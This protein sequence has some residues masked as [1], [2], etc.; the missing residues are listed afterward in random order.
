MR[1]DEGAMKF[2]M[3]GFFQVPILFCLCLAVNPLPAFTAEKVVAAYASISPSEVT[4][5]TAAKAG[6]F[7]KYGLEVKTV[8]MGGSSRVMEAMVSGDVDIAQ[9]GG[10]AVIYAKGAGVDVSYI[11]TIRNAM[12]SSIISRPE[13]KQM[14]DLKS[15]TLAVTR[16]GAITDFFGRLA[17]SH[18]GLVPDK[19]VKFLYTGGLQATYAA[20]AQSHVAAAVMGAGPFAARTL[21]EGFRELLD[22]ASLGADF[23]FNGIATM[24]KYLQTQRPTVVKFIKAYLEAIKLNLDDKPFTKKVLSEYTGFKEDDLLE[25]SYRVYIIQTMSRVPYPVARGWKA[26]IDFSSRENPRIKGLKIEEILDDR[27]IRELEESGF[28]KSLG[29]K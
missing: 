2:P 3:N 7:N 27:I 8:Y 25:E 1:L 26:V 17:L 23:P 21:K 4:L 29:L 18:F 19:D 28:V 10:T 9:I 6:L 20:L 14:G 15:K 13:I 5:L 11:A 24:R 16:R 12:I 22:I